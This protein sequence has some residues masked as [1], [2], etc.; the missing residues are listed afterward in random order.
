MG[1][2]HEGR[3]PLQEIVVKKRGVCLLEGGIFWEL[4][5]HEHTWIEL[6]MVNSHANTVVLRST[7]RIPNTQ[8]SPSM[9]RRITVAFKVALLA[10]GNKVHVE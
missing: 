2:L 9:G 10:R 8:V 7:V 4:T 3:I 1:H 6:Q 5:A